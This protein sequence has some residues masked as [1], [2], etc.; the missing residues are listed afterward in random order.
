MSNGKI[1][2]VNAPDYA[3]WQQEL[4]GAIISNMRAIGQGALLP[5]QG[6]G[7][8]CQFCEVRGLCRKGTW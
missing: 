6:T 1:D 5:A 4:R 3:S 2:Q 7:N 8:V